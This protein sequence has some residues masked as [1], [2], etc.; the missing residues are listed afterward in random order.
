M[1]GSVNK[2]ILDPS[3]LY[4]D[5]LSI[6]QVSRIT[7]IALSTLRFRFKAEGILRT[8]VQGVRIAAQG[9]RLGSGFRGKRRNFTPEH[10]AAISAGKIAWADENAV[11]VSE[12]PNGYIEYTRGEHKGRSVHVVAME[13]RIGRRL[14]PDE[15]VHHIDGN[16]LNNDSNNLALVTRS[17]HMRLHRREQR[18]AKGNA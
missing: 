12:K 9:G 5:G 10:C 15:C 17:G 14:L 6:P 16:P 13:E 2:V 7:G 1:S 4:L 18:I 8:R 11:G 3:R